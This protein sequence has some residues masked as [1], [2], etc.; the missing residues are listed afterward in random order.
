MRINVLSCAEE[1]FA[2]AVAYFNEQCPGLGYEFA[3]DVKAAFSRIAAFPE[4]WPT[5]SRRA[6]RC[7]V[8]RF[9]YGVLYQVRKDSILVLAIMHLA[10]DPKTWQDRLE[11][12]P[13]ESGR[14]ADIES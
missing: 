11:K 7:I 4:A 6:R 9:P 3:A 2:E 13:G 10:R 5:L 8:N 12:V 1:E 14:R